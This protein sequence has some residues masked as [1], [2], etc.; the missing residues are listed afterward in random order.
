[1][2]L[3]KKLW[4][5]TGEYSGGSP[6]PSGGYVDDVFSTYVYRGNGVNRSFV[7]G[8]NLLADGGMVWTKGRSGT[9]GATD[10]YLF[11]TER[12]SDIFLST[13]TTNGQGAFTAGTSVS[14]FNNDGFSIGTSPYVND[15]STKYVSW[16]FKNAPKFYGH[17]VVTKSAGSNASVSFPELGELGM[18]RVKHI[19][20]AGNWYVWHRSLPAGY[21]LFGEATSVAFLSNYITVFGTT[22]TLTDNVLSN[23]QYLVEA[24]AH[25]TALDGIVQC[26]SFETSGTVDPNAVISL[27]WEPQYVLY[28]KINGTSDWGV[29]DSYRGFYS[30][31]SIGGPPS[32]RLSGNSS[33]AE[34]TSAFA[35]PTATGFRT[36]TSATSENYV[37]IAIRRP[38]K[39]PTSGTQVYNAIA[40]TGTGTA[41][42]VTG[43]GFAPDLAIS[44]NRLSPSNEPPSWYDRV[45]GATF[46]MTS[47]SNGV[48]I[49]R[50]DTLTG[51]D[52]MDGVRVGSDTEWV[53]NKLGS[54]YINHYFRRAPGF[55]DQV[56]DTGTGSAH[57]PQHNLATI[58]QLMIRKAR[59][60]TT[61]WQVWHSALS[62]NEYLTLSSNAAKSTSSTVW[63]NTL[64]TSSVF[65][66]GTSANT[67]A[68]GILFVTYLFATVSGVSKVGSYSGN[69]GTQTI[70]CGFTTGSRFILIK[71]IDNTGDWFVWDTARGITPTTDPYLSLNTAAAE[72]TTDDSIDQDA[73]GFVVNQNAATNINAL[74]GNYLFLA[75]A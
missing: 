21:L 70:P 63:N 40:R 10:H 36:D 13:N 22:V 59:N 66:V 67:N 74:G 42:T 4:M 26:G 65:S 55:L 51:F 1:M 11:H 57:T 73:S 16:V 38:N 75:I 62:A 52:V 58:P 39:P 5:T 53:V 54:T 27:G 28:K 19:S 44:R 14:S 2:N 49:P 8:Q 6:T 35:H 34:T 24:F 33:S 69:G 41:A 64:P 31:D 45:R 15:S 72:V 46:Q 68:S 37:Y 20:D 71:R 60:A 61:D 32:P 50:P 9:Y 12:G 23:G 56:C 48:E 17:Q 43:V 7:T 18:V 29:F 3:A 47:N 25:D 30:S